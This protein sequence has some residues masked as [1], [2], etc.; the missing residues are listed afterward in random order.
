MGGRKVRDEL[1]PSKDDYQRNPDELPRILSSEYR[2]NNRKI[3]DSNVQESN[4]PSEPSM[5]VAGAGRRK[6]VARH[7][8]QVR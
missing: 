7:T 8:L 5:G 2:H 3:R 1:I 6:I 4:S